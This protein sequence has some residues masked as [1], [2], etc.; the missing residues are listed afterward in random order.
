MSSMGTIEN[1]LMREDISYS[2]RWINKGV[3]WTIC[4]VAIGFDMTPKLISIM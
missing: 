3:G 1:C 4:M 2:S